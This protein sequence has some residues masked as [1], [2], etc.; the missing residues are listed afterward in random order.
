M[1]VRIGTLDNQITT[2]WLADMAGNIFQRVNR[3]EITP[4]AEQDP[5]FLIVA[6]TV[7]KNY[8]ASED[9]E[10]KVTVAQ[11]AMELREVYR[12]FHQMPE[13]VPEDKE[14]SAWKAITRWLMFSVQCEGESAAAAAADQL[15]SK[16][17]QE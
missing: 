5:G 9:Q 1:S 14:I 13:A 8:L 12:N 17:L 16:A 15:V 3:P 10:I 7:V 11:H 4:E 2:D 6:K